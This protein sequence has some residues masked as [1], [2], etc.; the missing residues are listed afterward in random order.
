MAGGARRGSQFRDR[1]WS[2]Q[3]HSSPESLNGGVTPSKSHC[4][5]PWLSGRGQRSRGGGSRGVQSRSTLTLLSLHVRNGAGSP[6]PRETGLGSEHILKNSFNN[7]LLFFTTLPFLKSQVKN[8][9]LKER[10]SITPWSST[11]HGT[12]SVFP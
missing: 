12:P 6:G 10:L 4:R 2:T 11:T 9:C 7:T 5:R 8:Y 1:L 3:G